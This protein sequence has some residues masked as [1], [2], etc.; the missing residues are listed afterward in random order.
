MTGK[1][2]TVRGNLGSYRRDTV[3]RGNDP[4]NTPAADARSTHGMKRS[5]MAST[6]VIPVW[7]ICRADAQTCKCKFV[8]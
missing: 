7:L 2:D 1:L 6:T 4:N 5:G 3:I 8:N